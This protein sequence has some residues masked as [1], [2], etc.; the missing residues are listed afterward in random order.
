[1]F[2]ICIINK[3]EY[4]LTHNNFPLEQKKT[5]NKQTDESWNVILVRFDSLSI[6]G[7]PTYKNY[8]I[9]CRNRYSGGMEPELLSGSFNTDKLQLNGTIQ[10][11][12]GI[13]GASTAHNQVSKTKQI[14]PSREQA[15]TDKDDHLARCTHIKKSSYK[16]TSP[17]QYPIPIFLISFV[18]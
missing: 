4:M 17:S 11:T 7:T 3:L 18:L 14:V 6:T 12:I 13:I 9:K 16:I 5:G 15:W 1:M 8:Y 10:Q 2:S